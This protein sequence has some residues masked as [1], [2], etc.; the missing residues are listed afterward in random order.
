MGRC[1][2]LHH[3]IC[4]ILNAKS[5]N[6]TYMYAWEGRT[7]VLYVHYMIRLEIKRCLEHV[8]RNDSDKITVLNKDSSWH[9]LCFQ[10]WWKIYQKNSNL[11]NPSNPQILHVPFYAADVGLLAE[12]ESDFHKMLDIAHTFAYNWDIHLT[13]K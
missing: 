6:A 8:N 4:G 5:A 2:C 13:M 7:L 9:W 1:F 12:T 3:V 10:Y 11:S